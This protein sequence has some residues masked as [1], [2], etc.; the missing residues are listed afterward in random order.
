[1]LTSGEWINLLN[2]NSK[3]GQGKL[4]HCK[5]INSYFVFST[6]QSKYIKPLTSKE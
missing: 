3:I 5:K 2:K 4:S 6:A 1:M